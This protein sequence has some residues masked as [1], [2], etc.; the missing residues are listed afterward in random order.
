MSVPAEGIFGIIFEMYT[1][2]KVQEAVS[3]LQ[4]HQ[5]IGRSVTEQAGCIPLSAQDTRPNTT[6]NVRVQMQSGRYFE[7]QIGNP[8]QIGKQTNMIRSPVGTIRNL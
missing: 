8:P 6:T 3:V 5:V 7:R 4:A 1:M 2:F